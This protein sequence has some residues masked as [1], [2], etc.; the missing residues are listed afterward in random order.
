MHVSIDQ[1]RE[2]FT[3]EEKA[4]AFER[5]RLRLNAIRNGLGLSL[6]ALAV[7]TSSLGHGRLCDLLKGN[8]PLT[9]RNAIIIGE[10][11][12]LSGEELLLET[13]APGERLNKK[14][15]EVLTVMRELILEMSGSSPRKRPKAV[16]GTEIVTTSDHP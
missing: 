5:M 6:R 7:R 1:Q 15:K 11:L 13:V 14:S 9:V 12:G 3:P 8:Q 16:M 2:G 4:E 10:A